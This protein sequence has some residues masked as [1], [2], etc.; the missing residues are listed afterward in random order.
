M[1]DDTAAPGPSRGRPPR[2]PVRL[3]DLMALVAAVA[4]SLTSPAI[5]GAIIPAG[6]HAAWDRRPYVVH[7]TSLVLFWWTAALVVL[8]LIEP[9]PPLRRSCRRP[10][11]AAPLA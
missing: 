9:R 4:L 11:H 1:T 5:L 8:L 7:L 3:L 6:S 10:G 2:R